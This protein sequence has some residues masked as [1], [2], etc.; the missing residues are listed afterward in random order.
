MDYRYIGIVLKFSDLYNRRYY[1]VVR[2]GGQYQEWLLL[3]RRQVSAG[4]DIQLGGI[5]LMGKQKR[6]FLEPFWALGL[7]WIH[8][9]PGSAPPDAEVVRRRGFFDFTQDEGS[10]VAPD[11]MMGVNVGRMF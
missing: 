1:R 3:R 4:V 11:W 6:W 7:R 9:Q 8:N 5:H 2:Q 10:Y